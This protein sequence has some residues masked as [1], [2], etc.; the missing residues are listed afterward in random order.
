MKLSL[1]FMSI[2]CTYGS[3]LEWEFIDHVVNKINT[4]GLIVLLVDF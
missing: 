1:E 3:N 2:V 4:A